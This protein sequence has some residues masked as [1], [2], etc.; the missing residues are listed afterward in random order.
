MIN[1]IYNVSLIL[2]R[3]YVVVM[4]IGM[5]IDGGTLAGIIAFIIAGIMGVLSM[6]WPVIPDLE[7]DQKQTDQQNKPKR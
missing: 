2:V 6:P 3:L 1:I 7:E 5:I 4:G